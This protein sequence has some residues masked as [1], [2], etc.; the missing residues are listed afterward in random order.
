VKEVHQLSDHTHFKETKPPVI[1]ADESGG[2]KKVAVQNV[3]L[4]LMSTIMDM[5]ASSTKS[6]PPE[7]QVPRKTG[8]LPPLILLSATNLFQ[9]QKFTTPKQKTYTLGWWTCALTLEQMSIIHRAA[10]ETT[11]NL[12]PLFLISMMRAAKIQDIIKLP[13]LCHIQ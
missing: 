1:T 5:G 7:E 2:W 3:L 12:L 10:E 8:K 13:S 11:I 4:P 6:S 9:L